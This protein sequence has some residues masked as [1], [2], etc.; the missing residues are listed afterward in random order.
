MSQGK[1]R[2][3]LNPSCYT[4]AVKGERHMDWMSRMEKA[5]DYIEAHLT[6]TIDYDDLAHA[7]CCSAYHFPRMFMSLT[8]LSLSEYIRRRRLSC[9]GKDLQNPDMRVVDTAVKYGYDSAD[10]FSRAFFNQHR[11]LP[12]QVCGGSVQLTY[13]PRLTFQ[14]TIK[15]VEPMNY[16]LEDL[17]FPIRVVGKRFPVATHTAHDIIPGIWAR[18]MENGFI[19]KLIDMAWE[20]PKCRLASL[21]AICGTTPRI[22]DE[23]F[24]YFIGVRYDD[25]VPEG[26]AEVSLA[27]CTWAVFPDVYDAWKRVYTQWLPTSGYDLADL[28]MVECHYPPDHQP[29]TE[30]WVPVIPKVKCE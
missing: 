30:L 26:M 23:Q 4:G 11:T 19:P 27:P 10:A 7:A 12:S 24:D 2:M 6:E 5:L 29:G 8:D 18:Q 13:Y 20:K 22:H 28:P 14:L 21:L 16:R 9:A 3:D 17:D 15:G 1:S 25:P